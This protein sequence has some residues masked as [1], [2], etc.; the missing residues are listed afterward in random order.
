MKIRVKKTFVYRAD[1]GEVVTLPRGEYDSPK[2]IPKDVARLALRMRKAIR[3]VEKKAPENKV[4][5]ARSNKSEVERPAVH[6]RSAG[7]ESD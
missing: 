3:V 2:D 4:V 7:P 6:S 1:S 5:R